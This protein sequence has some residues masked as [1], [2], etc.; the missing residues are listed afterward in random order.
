[1]VTPFDEACSTT[2][3]AATTAIDNR[4]A[5][6]TRLILD[7]KDQVLGVEVPLVDGS[8][9]PAI[10]A[11]RSSIHVHPVEAAIVGNIWMGDGSDGRPSEDPASR[12]ALVVIR[13]RSGWVKT[14]C[15]EYRVGD[16]GEVTW[17][18]PAEGTPELCG[19]VPLELDDWLV[20]S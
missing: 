12:S 18:E 5:W 20:T 19:G 6:T 4:E 13:Q 2:F 1:M 17:A 3:A 10:R 8:L 9:V 11:L 14:L 16:R 7:L 15:C